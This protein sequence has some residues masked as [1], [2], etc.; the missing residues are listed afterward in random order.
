MPPVHPSVGPTPWAA[1]VRES[2]SRAV[3]GASDP[4]ELVQPAAGPRVT[5][6]QRQKE[7]LES[8]RVEFLLEIRAAWARSPGQGLH[9][10][11]GNTPWRRGR[12]CVSPE[13]GVLSRFGTAC[14][15]SFLWPIFVTLPWMSWSWIPEGM[16]G[17]VLSHL[18][19]KTWHCLP[20][21]PSLET[22]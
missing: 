12:T 20:N 5:S 6:P 21:H 15:A 3:Q 16:D 10:G 18:S 7:F 8:K 22:F 2:G 4:S 11:R 17:G 9:P 19:G 14:P 1:Q 13:H